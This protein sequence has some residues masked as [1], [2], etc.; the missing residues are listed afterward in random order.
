MPGDPSVSG[1]LLFA[2]TVPIN[3]F[4]RILHHPDLPHVFIP[5]VDRPS[6][7]WKD[8]RLVLTYHRDRQIPVVD[9]TNRYRRV[10]PPIYTICSR[11]RIRSFRY[12]RERSYVN[13]S[14]S[15]PSSSS[16]F[17]FLPHRVLSLSPTTT[18]RTCGL[19]FVH[20]CPEVGGRGTRD[21]GTTTVGSEHEVLRPR[22][23]LGCTSRRDTE[24]NG[25]TLFP[26]YY[27]PDRITQTTLP[28]S[29][30]M[31]VQG[32]CLE[33]YVILES[34]LTDNE[35]KVSLSDPGLIRPDHHAKGYLQKRT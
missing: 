15:S 10:R 30:I 24:P 14:P 35:G 9:R 16:T 8:P 27:Y 12:W 25:C 13:D 28:L 23:R 11:T 21:F 19:P 5:P 34:L 31:Y 32:S 1:Q 33:P 18:S 26:N 4:G 2:V 7:L 6:F 22:E 20:V 17:L 3:P 29:F